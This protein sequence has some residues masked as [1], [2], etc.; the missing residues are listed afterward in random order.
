MKPIINSN[1]NIRQAMLRLSLTKRKTLFVI[2]KKKTLLGSITDGDVRR[3]LLKGLKLKSSIN[4]IINKKPFFLYEK[5]YSIS[6]AK[7]I[8]LKKNIQS[9]PILFYNKEIKEI[10]YWNDLFTDKTKN[11]NIPVVIMA[12]GFG[13]RLLPFTNYLPK[14]L[15]TVNRKPM[16]EHIISNFKECGIKHYYIS[17]NYKKDLLIQYFKKRENVKLQFI[18]EKKPLGTIGSLSLLK[19]KIKTDFFVT[20]CDIAANINPAAILDFHKKQNNKITIITS[21]FENNI[22]YG[23][24][25][26]DKKGNL[27]KIIEKPEFKNFI[28]IGIYLFDKN[29]LKLLKKNQKINAN[30]LFELAKKKKIKIGVY[31][32]KANEWVD[33]G[34]WN[35]YK[36]SVNSTFLNNKS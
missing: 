7:E 12:G 34:Q 20:N 21:I 23:V 9:L 22:P 29:I 19:E 10:I 5:N 11:L 27:K 6:S 28:N 24:C 36:N 14:P 3:G 33:I 35:F 1:A 2:C 18:I 16:I 25:D 26:I 8:L 15:I 30:D 17:I 31:P 32:I 4:E 13:K